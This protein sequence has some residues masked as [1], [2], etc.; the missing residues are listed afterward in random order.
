MMFFFSRPD[1]G[2]SSSSRESER[3]TGYLERDLDNGKET[4]PLVEKD[5]TS[6]KRD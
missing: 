5:K 2:S 4:E 6:K 1:S 3:S